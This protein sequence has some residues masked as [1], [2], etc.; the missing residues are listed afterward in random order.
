MSKYTDIVKGTAKPTLPTVTKKTENKPTPTPQP[1]K[2]S[3]YFPQQDNKQAIK[4]YYA[5]QIEAIDEEQ[6]QLRNNPWSYKLMKKGTEI[7]NKYL[8]KGWGSDLLGSLPGGILRSVERPFRFLTGSGYGITQGIKGALGDKEAASD[9]N[10]NINPFMDEETMRRMKD[11]RDNTI[12]LK[13]GT[14]MAGDV[15]PLVIAPAKGAGLTEKLITGGAG[16]LTST[17]AED[18]PTLRSALTNLVFGTATAGAGHYTSK[19]FGKLR[20]GKTPKAEIPAESPQ[21]N[22]PKENLMLPEGGVQPKAPEKITSLAERPTTTP[23]IPEKPGKVTPTEP[24]IEGEI[25]DKTGL[26]KTGEGVPGGKPAPID[27]V[28]PIKAKSLPGENLFMSVKNQLKKFGKPGEKLSSMLDELE[29]Q[30]H[31]LANTSYNRFNNALKEFEKTSAAVPGEDNKAIVQYILDRYNGK[32][33]PEIGVKGKSVAES[34]FKEVTLPASLEA[35]RFNIHPAGKTIGEARMFLPLIIKDKTRW[36]ESMIDRLVKEGN[37]ADEAAKIVEHMIGGTE[38]PKANTRMFAGFEKARVFNPQ[39]FEELAQFGYETDLRKIAASWSKGA[40]R[41][42]A[43][44]RVLGSME[45]GEH[46]GAAKEFQEMLKAGVFQGDVDN[47]KRNFMQA[48]EGAPKENELIQNFGK[49]ARAYSG[50]KIGPSVAL[51]QPSTLGQVAAITG[52]RQTAGAII[53]NLA[54]KFG[55]TKI[56]PSERQ[57]VENAGV[58]LQGGLEDILRSEYG[59]GGTTI[60]NAI[61]KITGIKLKLSGTPAFD[62]AIRKVSAYASLDWIRSSVKKLASGKLSPKAQAALYDELNTFA[63]PMKGELDDIIARGGE[64]TPFE[65]S[66]AI[67]NFGKKTQFGLSR[68]ELPASWSSSTVGRVAT[69][70]K[71]FGFEQM[72]MYG[73]LL[74]HARKTKNYTPLI[75]SIFYTTGIN[76]TSA[77][78]INM[79]LGANGQKKDDS[80]A[81]AVM[82][83]LA[84][85]TL[86]LVYQTIKYSES[87]AEALGSLAAGPFFGD[88]ANLGFQGYKAAKEQVDNVR[89]GKRKKT[90]LRSFG[91]MIYNKVPPF[92]VV[93]QT[94]V[95]GPAVS[96]E[97]FPTSSGKTF[98]K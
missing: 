54:A 17:L 38:P 23:D 47:L 87:G 29:N 76:I 48:I 49:I 43:A 53:K 34:F 64:L 46:A 13:K 92:S 91:K 70:L 19:A 50:W 77:K 26:V 96:K 90:Q 66:K 14:Q 51:Q 79:L 63:I 15:L 2:A 56:D 45:G 89:T 18:K 95:V 55:L 94:P 93:R 42:I 98:S 72:Q 69:Q 40:W 25:V 61:E 24:A 75:K 28:E 62:T 60:T 39:T 3:V 4:D 6:K 1:T 10:N 65:T 5:S 86:G 27:A 44:Y 59:S 32:A 97:L 37:S 80:W 9:F 8:G 33:A 83:G 73:R 58:A 88:V 7:T 30:G 78:V 85:T 36:A 20:S 21:I 41:R 11:P 67:Y 22:A 81:Q 57:V 52:E 71:S 16:G 12:A 84:Q 82:D 31:V 35:K 74:E 68:A